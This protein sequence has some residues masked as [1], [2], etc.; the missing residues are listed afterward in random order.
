[1]S[2]KGEG[3]MWNEERNRDGRGTEDSVFHGSM[4]DEIANQNHQVFIAIRIINRHHL[5]YEL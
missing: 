3:R 5:S 1:V 4:P 2:L